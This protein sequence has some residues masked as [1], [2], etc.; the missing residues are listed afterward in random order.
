MRGELTDYDW[1]RLAPLLPSETGRKARP[2]KAN[3]KMVDAILWIHRTGAPWRDLPV[4]Y[5][6]WKSVYSRFRRW[7]LQGIWSRVLNGLSIDRDTEMYMLDSSVVRAHQ[8][9]AG[10]KRG[11]AA[12]RSGAL[13]VD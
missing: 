8:H 5:G 3:R 10:G 12:K 9:A 6:P 7:A 4:Q 1:N 11:R 13:V 2:S